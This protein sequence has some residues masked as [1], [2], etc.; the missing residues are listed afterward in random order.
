MEREPKVAKGG[1]DLIQAA[2][3]YVKDGGRLTPSSKLIIALSLAEK[4]EKKD[5]EA[6]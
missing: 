6:R 5:D 3:D 1:S 2:I 4:E